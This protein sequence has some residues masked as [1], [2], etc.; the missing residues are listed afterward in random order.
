[1][2]S[3]DLYAQAAEGDEATVMNGD[4]VEQSRWVVPANGSQLLVVQ[5]ESE[6]MGTF[7]ENLVFEVGL[8][9]LHLHKV[10]QAMVRS[11]R[12]CCTMLYN[13]LATQDLHILRLQHAETV[14]QP[15]E[16]VD[17]VSQ[18]AETVDQVTPVDKPDK[19]NYG[20]VTSASLLIVTLCI[21]SSVACDVTH[22]A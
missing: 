2:G 11:N 15:A 14:D 10:Y 4:K 21:H 3:T 1:M 22:A 8:Y 13:V 9:S 6:D 20:D 18:H 5:F 7:R 19:A 17:Q 16:T 12:H